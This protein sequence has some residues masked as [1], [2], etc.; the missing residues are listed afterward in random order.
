MA[1]TTSVPMRLS[2]IRN[3]AANQGDRRE[4]LEEIIE[5]AQGL[6]KEFPKQKK[7]RKETGGRDRMESGGHDRSDAT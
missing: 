7:S 3:L 6:L 1:Q 4:R 5:I 2:R